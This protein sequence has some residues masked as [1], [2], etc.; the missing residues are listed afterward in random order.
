MNSKLSHN[1]TVPQAHLHL[2]LYLRGRWSSTATYT[3]TKLIHEVILRAFIYSIREYHRATS[4]C[5]LFTAFLRT[6][7]TKNTAHRCPI[8][9]EF[10]DTP[11]SLLLHFQK[12]HASSASAPMRAQSQSSSNCTYAVSINDR[13]AALGSVC[14]HL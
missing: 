2:G 14:M 12:Y 13:L 11:P 3:K 7:K 8:Q 9:T 1:L 4:D 5:I 6:S 10:R